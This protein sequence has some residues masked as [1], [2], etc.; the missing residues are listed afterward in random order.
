MSAPS[1]CMNNKKFRRLTF[2]WPWILWSIYIYLIF[3][4]GILFSFLQLLFSFFRSFFCIIL[5]W[6]IF[7]NHG[8]TI[9]FYS[10][11]LIIGLIIISCTV[12]FIGS[13]IFFKFIFKS[14]HFI[15]Y[16]YF[17]SIWLFTLFIINI[18]YF[19]FFIK[20]FIWPNLLLIHFL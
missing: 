8:W 12:L 9:L 1:W 13:F 3:H 10:T 14:K 4:R 11:S 18:L 6:I 15:S 7:L 16:F 17:W 20:L 19:L 5:S 2:P